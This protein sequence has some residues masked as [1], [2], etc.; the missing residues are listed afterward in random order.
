MVDIKQEF[1]DKQT[2]LV[3]MPG[4]EYYK[5]TIDIVKQLSGSP[6]CYVTLNKTYDALLETFKSK[7]I[8]HRL[9]FCM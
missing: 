6:I 5:D 7:K 1:A 2:L 8:M 3:L 4:L 9:K